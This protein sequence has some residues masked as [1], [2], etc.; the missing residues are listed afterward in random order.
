MCRRKDIRSKRCPCD[1]PAPRRQR[2][3]LAYAVATKGERDAREIERREHKALTVQEMV[4]EL[5]NAEEITQAIASSPE[6][7]REMASRLRNER[8]NAEST[9]AWLLNGRENT[10]ENLAE[11]MQERQQQILAMGSVLAERAQSIHGLDLD[12]EHNK[13]QERLSVSE[14][15]LA[16]LRK[17]QEASMNE[18]LEVRKGLMKKYDKLPYELKGN[19][20]AE[21]EA[22]FAALNT[23][24]RDAEK[25]YDKHR[26]ATEDIL[27]G[28]DPET[29]EV[30][31]KVTEANRQA[32]RETRSFGAKAPGW[33]S[34]ISS[35]SLA[36]LSSTAQQTF[37]DDWVKSSDEKGELVIRRVGSKDG[38]VHYI[39]VHKG[40]HPY[41]YSTKNK[42]D[43]QD[44][45]FVG[46]SEDTDEQGNGTGVWRG[47]LRDWVDEKNTRNFSK[48]NG[49]TPKGTGWVR[50][51]VPTDSG[52]YVTGW[53]R[54]NPKDAK[55]IEALNS[56]SADITVNMAADERDQKESMQH[57]FAHRVQD[58]RPH[59]TTMELA[60]IASRTTDENGVRHPLKA[61]SGTSVSDRPIR[62]NDEVV[63]EDNWVTPYM[64]REYKDTNMNEFLSIGT[65]SVF[66]G[67]Y[68]GM[69]GIGHA[70][71]DHETRNWIMGAYATL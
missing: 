10:P 13:W 62:P 56:Q 24:Y 48:F 40:A 45:R 47:P 5:P 36:H 22:T 17:T 3:N 28:R 60:Y 68:G 71:K 67:N 25:A 65:E 50:G 4:A 66:G 29:L 33:T 18:Y 52:D 15:E 49:D 63:R 2:Q 7:S 26:Q 55:R 35:R 39:P 31:D 53:V 37:P 46:W 30:V 9:E 6:V 61:Y 12:E 14:K 44:S 58:S 11:G 27:R 69:V 32:V 19:M 42:P 43:A 34:S 54:D 57:E 21:D 59:I 51:K 1:D 64:G 41:T 70:K 23:K 8:E 16:E 38:R 20:D